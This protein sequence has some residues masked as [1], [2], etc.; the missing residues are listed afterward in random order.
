MI[1][2]GLLAGVSANLTLVISNEGLGSDI[3]TIVCAGLGTDI[4]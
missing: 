1:H 2:I 3:D 4:G